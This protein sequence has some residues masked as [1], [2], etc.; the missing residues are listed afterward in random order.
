MGFI[1]DGLIFNA[2]SGPGTGGSSG[3]KDFLDSPV[4][5]GNDEKRLY[6]KVL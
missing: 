4:K 2:R 5:P 1:A 3:L 6:S